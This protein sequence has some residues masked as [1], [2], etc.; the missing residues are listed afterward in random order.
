LIYAIGDSHTRICE[1]HKG[2]KGM[3]HALVKNLLKAPTAHN[4]VK[5]N[6]TNGMRERIFDFLK[7]TRKS[8]DILLFSFGE[9]DCR[10]H[11][12]RQH[13]LQGVS[14]S[15]LIDNT[16]CRYSQFIDEI[17][18]KGYTVYLLGIP[19]C[20]TQGNK[21]KCDYYPLPSQ[22]A[23]IFK[24]FNDRMRQRFPDIYIDMYS[25]TADKD[26]FIKKE[27]QRDDIHLNEKAFPIVAKK[28]E[29]FKNNNAKITQNE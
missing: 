4:L 6:S 29:E 15:R 23:E 13:V 12:Y 17:T 27:Y 20:G 18:E 16:I 1:D 11:F 7:Q 25:P 2:Y 28:M 22:Q 24:L 8:R 9:L 5:E 26:G 19:P 14:I 21:F 10:I 3:Y